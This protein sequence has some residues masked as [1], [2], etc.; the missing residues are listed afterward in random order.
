MLNY[1][2]IFFLFSLLILWLSAQI[3]LY[4]RRRWALKDDEREDFSVVQTATLTLLALII[5][6]SPVSP[7]SGFFAKGW[8]SYKPTV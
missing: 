7:A 4:V 2:R 1:P 6:F 3:G 5:G 8:E